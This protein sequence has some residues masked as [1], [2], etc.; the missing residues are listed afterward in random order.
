MNSFIKSTIFDR[1]GV[2]PD[3]PNERR[4][5]YYTKFMTMSEIYLRAHLKQND[6]GLIPSS[7]ESVV[8]DVHQMQLKRRRIEVGTAAY[9]L[10][11]DCFF[12]YFFN[13]EYLGSVGRHST[14]DVSRHQEPEVPLMS[15]AK[16]QDLQQ[17]TSVETPAKR[18]KNDYESQEDETILYPQV[19]DQ[20]SQDVKG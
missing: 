6:M 7:K 17:E 4:P 1:A 3:F 11:R 18:R 9:F 5:V 20:L 10:Y 2:D 8:K 16:S 14:I 19:H 12:E 15:P 13:T